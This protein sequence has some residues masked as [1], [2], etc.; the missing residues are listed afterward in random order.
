MDR[1]EAIIRKMQEI[2]DE[3]KAMDV[4]IDEPKHPKRWWFDANSK[5]VWGSV[6]SP[7]EGLYKTLEITESYA[8]YLSNKPEGECELM[9]AVKGDTIWS[10]NGFDPN[11]S[12]WLTDAG[13]D[14]TCGL[15]DLG[16]RWV[17]TSSP[18]I[19][20][21][22]DGRCNGYLLILGDFCGIAEHTQA[23][24]IYSNGQES[25][26]S[27]LWKAKGVYQSSYRYRRSSENTEPVTPVKVVCARRGK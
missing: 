1:K 25:P 14:F 21:V 18:N 23:S 13:G 6:L 4:I 3:V 15:N 24:Y 19:V 20:P 26:H 9:M 22:V 27:W 2:V 12:I 8:K 5:M 7:D 17:K 10:W 11:C 16:Y